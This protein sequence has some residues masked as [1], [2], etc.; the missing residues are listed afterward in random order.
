V[1]FLVKVAIYILTEK[2]HNETTLQELNTPG[3][4]INN[5]RTQNEMAWTYH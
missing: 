1:A 5:E 4:D 2:M 3:T